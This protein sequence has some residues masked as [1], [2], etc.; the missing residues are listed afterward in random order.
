MDNS[1]NSKVVSHKQTEIV[2]KILI[3][4][5][6]NRQRKIIVDRDVSVRC[7]GDDELSAREEPVP[8][9]DVCAARE[10]VHGVVTL[11]LGAGVVL[12]L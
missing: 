3:L 4:D 12:E 11:E 2:P 5:F 1:V 7:V 8:V 6:V 10:V 9:L